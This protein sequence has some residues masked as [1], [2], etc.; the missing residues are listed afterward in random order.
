MAETAGPNSL[1]GQVALGTKGGADV[2]FHHFRAASACLA[3]DEVILKL[4]FK[5]A[6]NSCSREVIFNALKTFAP[7]TRRY[8]TAALSTTRLVLGD[9]LIDSA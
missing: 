1:C 9:Q 7:S 6:F 3:M 2:V 5:N 8:A 4:D